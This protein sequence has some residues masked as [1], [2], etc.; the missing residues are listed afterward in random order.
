MT[1]ISTALGAFPLVV[2][3]GPGSGAVSPGG[4]GRGLAGLRELCRFFQERD[5]RCFIDYNPWDIGT[6]REPKDDLTVLAQKAAA[7][8]VRFRLPEGKDRARAEKAARRQVGAGLRRI[9]AR[10]LHA[11]HC[12]RLVM[13]R[14][15]SG[16]RE[17]YRCLGA[18]RLSCRSSD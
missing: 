17:P 16:D 5:V 8:S 12:F 13:R 6:R 11:V 4:S 15:R 14:S 9:D 18:L 10:L 3:S 1:S 7:G 2:G